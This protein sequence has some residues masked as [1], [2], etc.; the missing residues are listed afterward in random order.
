MA[1]NQIKLLKSPAVSVTKGSPLVTLTGGINAGYVANGTAIWI[2]NHQLVEA[3]SGSSVDVNGNSTITLLEP[4]PHDDVVNEPLAALNSTEGLG[5]AIRGARSISDTT[6]VMLEKFE[7]LVSSTQAS[8]DIEINGEL[9]SQVRRKARSAPDIYRA[10]FFSHV[11]TE[12]GT[13]PSPPRRW[14]CA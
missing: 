14:E 7:Q 4:W 1:L 11:N 6:L 2:G 10:Y 13:F 3:K 12:S 8:I 9:V 5:E